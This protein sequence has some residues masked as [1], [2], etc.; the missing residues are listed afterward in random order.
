MREITFQRTDDDIRLLAIY[1]AQLTKENITYTIENY[2][3]YVVVNITG[4]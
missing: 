2:R 1:I 3:N 4:Y